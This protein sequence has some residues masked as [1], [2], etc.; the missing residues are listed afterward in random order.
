MPVAGG[1]LRYG[2]PKHLGQ[3]CSSVSFGIPLALLSR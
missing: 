2:K 3:F 1:V